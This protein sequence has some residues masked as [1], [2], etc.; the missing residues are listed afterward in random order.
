MIYTTVVPTRL[1]ASIAVTI[2]EGPSGALRKVFSLKYEDVTKK[3]N[4]NSYN[5]RNEEEN[6]T[7]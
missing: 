3:K 5:G 6:K 7:T 2:F 4:S 1:E